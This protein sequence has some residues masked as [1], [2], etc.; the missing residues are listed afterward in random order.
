LQLK[1][2]LEPIEGQLSLKDYFK[3]ALF[4]F[5]NL[6]KTYKGKDMSKW[7]SDILI[8]GFGK[9]YGPSGMLVNDHVDS[10]NGWL[11]KFLIE[12]DKIL[13]KD[14]KNGDYNEKL[15]CISTCPMKIVDTINKISDES[16]LFAGIFGYK[17]DDK[18]FNN[19]ISL[20][21]VHGWG[22]VLPEKSPLRNHKNKE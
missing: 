3:E 9:S 5:E 7:W 20:K 11:V 17:V 21:P 8:Q 6:L 4:V 13:A 16:T 19:V 18:T 10:Y 2:I 15:N 12:Y 1:K 22:L 14:L